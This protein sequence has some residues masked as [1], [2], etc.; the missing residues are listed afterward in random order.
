MN[1]CGA[2]GRKDASNEREHR[3]L[4]RAAKSFALVVSGLILA[5][6][7]AV[8][9]VPDITA[10]DKAKI[11]RRVTLHAEMIDGRLPACAE[12][13]RDTRQLDDQSDHEL[14]RIPE[15]DLNGRRQ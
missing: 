3:M 7:V 13:A 10:F 4:P 14:P 2:S 15:D 12:E 11:T 6:G 9:V 1:P 5:L 8:I